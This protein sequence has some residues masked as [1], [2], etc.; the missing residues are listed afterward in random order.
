MWYTR[1]GLAL[2][3]LASALIAADPSVGTWKIN[4]EKSKL[5]NPEAWKGRGMIIEATGPDSYKVTFERPKADGTIDRTTDVV[6]L[7]G[8]ENPTSQGSVRVSKR[9]DAR[10]TYDI[11]KKDGKEVGSLDSVISPDGKTMT[12]H[13]KTVDANGKEQEDF[14]VFDKQ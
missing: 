3:M 12:N 13:S 4:I 6:S 14:R 10:H 9:I 7:D 5:R 8:K 2:V 1:L 11:F